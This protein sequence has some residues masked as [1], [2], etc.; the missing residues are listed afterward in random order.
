VFAKAPYVS[1]QENNSKFVAHVESVSHNFSVDYNGSR[2][3]YCGINFVRGVFTD[4]KIKRIYD[5][6]SYGIDTHASSIPDSK[7]I[8]KATYEVRH[9]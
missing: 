8:T 4:S 9:G 1:G 5:K 7:E 6:D 3:Y 2:S